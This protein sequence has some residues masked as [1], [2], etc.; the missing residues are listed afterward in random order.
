MTTIAIAFLVVGWLLCSVVAYGGTFAYYQG[1]LA[2]PEFN[3]NQE[4]TDRVF[5][6]IVALLGGPIALVVSFF[7]TSGY[8][9]RFRFW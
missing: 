8:K 6:A 7:Y 4:N 9:Y 2:Y 1:Y 5:C 3:K